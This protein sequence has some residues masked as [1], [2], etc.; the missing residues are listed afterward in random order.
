MKIDMTNNIRKF[1]EEISARLSTVELDGA[2]ALISTP[3]CYPSGGSVVVRLSTHSGRIFVSDN[4]GGSFEADLMGGTDIYSKVGKSVSQISGVGFDQYS[5]F[6][7]E[8]I[9]SRSVGAVIAVANCSKEAVDQTAL[10][11]AD[12]KS[13]VARS[14]LFDRLADAFQAERVSFDVELVGASNHKWHVDATVVD[15]SRLTVFDFVKPHA[16][17][18]YSAY[19]KF[20]DL[21][22]LSSAPSNVAVVNSRKAMGDNLRL[23]SQTS[24]VIEESANLESIRKLVAA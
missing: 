6:I 20:N 5:F 7:A 22:K 11:L 17:S 8:V 9:E 23:L 16:N 19:A 15:N 21:N 13:T 24:S 1:S 10:K 2:G 4:G 18:V 12:K 3:L 14:V